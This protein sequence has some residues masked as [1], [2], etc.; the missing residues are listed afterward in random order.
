MSPRPSLTPLAFL[1]VSAALGLPHCG[2]QSPG[3]ATMTP[4]PSAAPPVAPAPSATADASASTC[5]LPA[6]PPAHVDTRE[7]PIDC[8]PGEL[9]KCAAACKAGA[10]RACG[11]LAHM[12]LDGNGV[13]ADPSRGWQ[14][15]RESCDRGYQRACVDLGVGVQKGMA[16]SAADPARAAKLYRQGCDAGEVLGC[17]N[18]ANLYAM[19][20]GVEKDESCAKQIF[21]LGCKAG[22][23]LSC[24]N[25][26][27]MIEKSEPERSL[28][29]VR[30]L[31]AQGLVMSCYVVALQLK[32]QGADPK[33]VAEQTIKACDMGSHWACNNLGYLYVRGE[34]VDKDAGR[35]FALFQKACTKEHANGCDSLGEA[36]EKGYGTPVDL[37][38]AKESY[39]RAC[40]WGFVKAC[41]KK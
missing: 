7:P 15:W 31:C 1:A 11:V 23:L 19:G 16:G 14:L 28:T 12:Y 21:D 9:A 25:Y 13:Q 33:L 38:K 34:G 8:K 6:K 4:T 27:L 41:A 35:G 17:E 3:P 29:M 24:N 37:A 5:P 18:L 36:Y 39:A 10:E 22:R 20:N 30:D 2:G 26:A 40:E 32:R